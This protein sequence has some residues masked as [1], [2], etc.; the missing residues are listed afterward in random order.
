MRGDRPLRFKE[1]SDGLSNTLL[2]GEAVSEPMAWGSP[3]NW[4][5]PRLGVNRSRDGFGGPWRT[6]PGAGFV[7]GDGSTRFI[8]EEIDP[9]VLEALATPSGGEKVDTDQLE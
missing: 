1:F 2:S 6:T 3:V 9:R 5:D 7:M 4:R 8:N